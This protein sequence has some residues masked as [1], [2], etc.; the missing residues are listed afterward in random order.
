[1]IVGP[2]IR[3]RLV[4]RFENLDFV[5]NL[6]FPL[7]K[8]SKSVVDERGHRLR[9]LHAHVSTYYYTTYRFRTGEENLIFGSIQLA[10]SYLSSAALCDCNYS[11][12]KTRL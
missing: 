5:R 12:T 6:L 10:E 1:M 8:N 7:L 4:T 9:I 3:T 11:T 2:R